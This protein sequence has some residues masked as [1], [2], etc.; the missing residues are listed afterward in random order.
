MR[1]GRKRRVDDAPQVKLALCVWMEKT[2]EA[3]GGID[4]DWSLVLRSSAE[5]WDCLPYDANRLYAAKS[6]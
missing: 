2:H 6:R 5:E 3:M 1:G 4:E